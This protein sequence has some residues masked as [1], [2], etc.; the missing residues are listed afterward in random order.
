MMKG[1]AGSTLGIEN[2]ICIEIKNRVWEERRPFMAYIEFNNVTEE[3][4]TGETSIK[5]LD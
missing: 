5:A 4:M 3:Y 1:S 2:G